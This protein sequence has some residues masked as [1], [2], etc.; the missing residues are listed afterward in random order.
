MRGSVGVFASRRQEHALAGCICL[1]H[2]GYEGAA[3]V[4]GI[5]G[6]E[7]HRRNRHKRRGSRAAA[8][9]NNNG[10]SVG[11]PRVAKSLNRPVATAAAV[12]VAPSRAGPGRVSGLGRWMCPTR[13][14]GQWF[15]ENLPVDAEPPAGV[16]GHSILPR[17][18]S[19]KCPLL[20]RVRVRSPWDVRALLRGGQVGSG[21]VGPQPWLTG[22]SLAT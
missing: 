10:R 17:C 19:P 1:L 15:R 11:K 6:K 3:G 18:G 13:T 14:S 5:G 2:G 4:G 20:I 16:N 7:I 8:M 22:A 12:S 9:T 21:R